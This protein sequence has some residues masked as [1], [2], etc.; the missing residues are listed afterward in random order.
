VEMFA[1]DPEA[2]TAAQH[3]SWTMGL[4]DDAEIIEFVCAEG[5]ES[6]AMQR[7]PWKGRP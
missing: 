2:W 1:E 6:K 7:A 4:A 5:Y 3:H